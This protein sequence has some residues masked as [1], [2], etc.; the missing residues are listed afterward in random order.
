MLKLW[1]YVVV[2]GGLLAL[3]ALAVWACLYAASRARQRE[4]EI[5]AA[6]RGDGGRGQGA[7]TVRAYALKVDPNANVAR[8]GRPPTQEVT[9]FARCD[10]KK[11]RLV[12]SRVR[13]QGM[14]WLPLQQTRE[15][16]RLHQDIIDGSV[17]NMLVRGVV[18]RVWATR[19]NT[20]AIVIGRLPNDGQALD[21]PKGCSPLPV[22][23]PFQAQAQSSASWTKLVR[24]LTPLPGGEPILLSVWAF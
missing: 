21:L 22:A 3:C 20:S 1:W 23:T 2:I 14:A 24:G 13:S 16:L 6:T 7:G 4:R 17:R 5:C 15:S 8:M 12:T 18:V 10:R 9:V 19:D 11:V